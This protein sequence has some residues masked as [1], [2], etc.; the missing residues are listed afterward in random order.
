MGPITAAHGGNE[1]V[2]QAPGR[3]TDCAHS[4]CYA[5]RFRMDHRQ[6]QQQLPLQS[7]SR[8]NI[9]NKNRYRIVMA[10]K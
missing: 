7:A 8:L 4:H 2:A 5:I 1:P 10:T 6:R 3:Q 9:R